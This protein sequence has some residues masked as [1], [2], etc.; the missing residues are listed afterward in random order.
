MKIA[1]ILVLSVLTS[2]CVVTPLLYSALLQIFGQEFWP[3]SRVFNRVVL[4]L[5]LVGLFS[6]RKRLRLDL[7]KPYF[8]AHSWRR[9]LADLSLGFLLTIAVSTPLLF[10]IVGNGQLA[11]A[12]HGWMYLSEKFF[13]TLPA[14]LVTG[15]I[16]ESIFR[17]LLLQ[18]LLVYFRLIPAVL[19]ASLI[20][21]WVHFITPDNSYIL[22]QYSPIDGLLYFAH[23]VSRSLSSSLLPAIAGLTLV[24]VALNFALLRTRSVFL[25]I[26]MHAG[27]IIVVKMSFFSTVV[28]P[29]A[30][31]I[32]GIGR[33]YFL[34]AEPITWVSVLLVLFLVQAY[35]SRCVKE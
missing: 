6:M 12:N 14:A 28:V 21:G 16:E 2:A 23:V 19:C 4:A 34:V 20:Y 17:V 33:R 32:D 8:V 30:Q 18:G 11:W 26:G 3:Y 31:F 15:V 5:F 1:L 27:W 22:S 7:L 35:V 9:R 10:L 24:G 13:K 25:G 29:G